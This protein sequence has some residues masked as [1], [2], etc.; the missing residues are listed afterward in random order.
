MR[1]N[2]EAALSRVTILLD[3]VLEGGHETSRMKAVGSTSGLVP[4][5]PADFGTS[6]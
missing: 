4:K 2:F 1:G 5:C 3:H 6:L